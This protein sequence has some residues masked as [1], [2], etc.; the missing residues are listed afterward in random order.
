MFLTLLQV[1]QN[2]INLE[3]AQV[4]ALGFDPMIKQTLLDVIATAKMRA[5]QI[6]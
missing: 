5:G 1:I 4:D 3:P 6:M 2:L